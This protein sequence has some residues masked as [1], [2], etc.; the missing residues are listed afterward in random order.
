MDD[1]AGPSRSLGFGT[2]IASVPSL[3]S[4]SLS[5]IRHEFFVSMYT[6]RK[7]MFCS[8]ISSLTIFA[9]SII[10]SPLLI[11][12][13]IHSLFIVFKGDTIN[14]SEPG[15]KNPASTAKNVHDAKMGNLKEKSL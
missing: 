7:C 15:G 8:I 11:Y 1:E 10:S 2:A 13:F 5:R 6:A 12:S 14:A 9:R 3:S 4:F